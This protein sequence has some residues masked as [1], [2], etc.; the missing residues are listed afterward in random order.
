M[1]SGEHRVLWNGET[2]RGGS[3]AAG[4]YFVRLESPHGIQTEKVM[5]IE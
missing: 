4:V 2:D 5:R 3:A 1:E